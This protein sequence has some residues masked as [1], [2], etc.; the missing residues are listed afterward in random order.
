MYSSNK[1]NLRSAA[2]KILV[3][4]IIFN[5]IAFVSMKLF[6]IDLNLYAAFLYKETRGTVIHVA[7]G[8]TTRYKHSKGSTK[9]HTVTLASYEANVVFDD[10]SGITHTVHLSHVNSSLYEG[11]TVTLYYDPANPD[12]A[13]LTSSKDGTILVITIF[14]IV[15]LAAIAAIVIMFK[16]SGASS[17]SGKINWNMSNSEFESRFKS[18]DEYG[19]ELTERANDILGNNNR[20]SGL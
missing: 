13:V 12:N 2:S 15:D 9:G 7:E 11:E 4:L 10:E 8:H 19:G 5:L 17:S 14:L 1:S 20:S 16:K 3:L 18:A 6:N